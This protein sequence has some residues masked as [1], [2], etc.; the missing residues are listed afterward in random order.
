MQQRITDLIR[1]RTQ[2]IAAISH[3]LRTPITRLKLRAQFIDDPTLY[4]KII[5]DLDEMESMVAETLN[6]ASDEH[7]KEKKV[8]L[9]VNALLQSLCS[10]MQDMGFT[11]IYHDPVSRLPLFARSICLK[12]AFTNLIH[13]G[14]K[15]G[16]RVVV[17][18]HK[19]DTG[20]TIIIE[21][22]GPGLSDEQIKQVFKPFYRLESSR[23]RQT[24]G[25]GLGLAVVE[26]IIRA[27]HGTVTLTRRTQAKGLCVTVHF[28]NV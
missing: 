13:N 8:W 25:I 28:P 24:G 7:Q 20:L 27:H 15:Y 21:D 17:S 9:D 19:D 6:F 1:E 12:R 4:N 3:D 23:S 2:M 10:D 14:V 18:A 26:D 16:D 11:V 22:E 5:G